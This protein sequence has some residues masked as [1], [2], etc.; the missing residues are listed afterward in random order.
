MTERPN[1]YGS[2]ST[3]GADMPKSVRKQVPSEQLPIGSGAAK[4]ARVSALSPL[5]SSLH[6]ALGGA[7]GS[8]LRYQAGRG[9]TQW[10]GPQAVSAFPW[11]TL[12]VNIVG[13][14][15]MGLLAGWLAR[16]SEGAEPV[17]L[18]IGVGLLG[19]FTTFSAFSLEMMVLIERGQAAQ[20]FVYA[21]VSVLA[22]L[23]A[24]YV[25]L[26]AMRVAA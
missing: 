21:A 2:G 23:S 4:A 16:H 14:L 5:M 10:L 25:G 22:G 26:I 20:A 15:A 12:A 8:V 24:L 19:G 1:P 6:V 7:I 13:S 17:R 18:L 9:I 3:D 11:A